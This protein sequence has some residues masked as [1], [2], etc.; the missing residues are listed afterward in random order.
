MSHEPGVD[1]QESLELL[2]HAARLLR[3]ADLSRVSAQPQSPGKAGCGTAF[4]TVDMLC[5]ACKLGATE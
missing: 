2:Q 4:V 3:A 1:R 5:L